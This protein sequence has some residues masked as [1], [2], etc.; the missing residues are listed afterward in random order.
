MICRGNQ[1]FAATFSSADAAVSAATHPRPASI[2][3]ECNL[4]AMHAM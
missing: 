3:K 1:P 2:V 4:Q